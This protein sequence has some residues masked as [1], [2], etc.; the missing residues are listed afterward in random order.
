MRTV[1]GA[2]TAVATVAALAS[3]AACALLWTSLADARAEVQ[4]QRSELRE[5]KGLAIDT[6]DTVVLQHRTLGLLIST[7]RNMLT[8]T[9]QMTR[10]A[11]PARSLYSLP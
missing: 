1:L 4:S 5:V 6:A 10:P 3:L 7:Q 2:A 9:R 8:I 11:P